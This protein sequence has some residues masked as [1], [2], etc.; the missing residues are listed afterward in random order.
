MFWNHKNW[1][2]NLR[3]L[4]YGVTAGLDVQTT[5]KDYLTYRDFVETGQ[6]IGQRAFMTAQ[7][8]FGNNDFKS[9]DA[10]LFLFAALQRA[11]PHEQY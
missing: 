2:F 11:L 1:T 3:N 9:Y 6:S 4:A 7:G 8:I 5:Y 10:T